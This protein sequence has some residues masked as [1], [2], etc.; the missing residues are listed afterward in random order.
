MP[1]IVM[2]GTQQQIKQDASG[3][4]LRAASLESMMADGDEELC[5]AIINKSI[6]GKSSELESTFRVWKEK[7]IKVKLCGHSL[8]AALVTALTEEYHEVADTTFCFNAFGV[9]TARA[10]NWES[11]HP[12][13]TLL[14]FDAEGDVVPASGH[15]LI[16]RH[17]AIKALF[18]SHKNP[19]LK[20]HS[21][22][23]LWKP[24]RICEIDVERENGKWQ[25]K[26]I[27]FIRTLIG[28][29]LY[30]LTIIF[31]KERIP[32]WLKDRSINQLRADEVRRLRS[33]TNSGIMVTG[34]SLLR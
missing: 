4:E 8:G 14:N 9:T 16:G 30:Y 18:E 20:I 13:P 27:E 2:R 23:H 21:S 24:F 3:R 34:P 12:K 29:I 31:N 32:D 26:V 5:D 17:F 7:K 19:F 28:K 33:Y 22:K 11:C 10:L 1:W 25:R 6:A 15:R